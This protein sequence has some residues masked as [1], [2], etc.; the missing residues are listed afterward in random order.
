MGGRVLTTKLY[1]PPHR[2]AAIHRWQLTQRL[3]AAFH[4]NHQL[5]L[6]SAPAGY[7]KTTLVAEWTHATLNRPEPAA[8]MAWLSLED[9]DNDTTR[10]L[11]YWISSI[12]RMDETIGQ[13]A[14][15]LLGM[16][17]IPPPR[18]IL[19]ELL[20]ELATLT[21]QAILVLDDYHVISNTEL[22]EALEHFIQHRPTPVHLVITTR[23][24]P[25]FPLARLRSRGMLT[26]IR[27]H[28]LRFTAE[29]ALRFFN[30]SMHLDLDIDAV[31]ALETRTEGWAA[32]LQLAGMAIRNLPNREDFLRDFNGTH[33]YIIDYLLDEVLEHQSPAT[34]EFLSR[35][36]VLKR[37]NADLARTVT[38]NPD[39]AAILAH[40]ERFNL[41]LVPLDDQRIWYRYHQLLADVLHTGLTA[42]EEHEVRTRAAGWL[43]AHELL[44]E[45]IPHWLAIGFADQAGRLINR[46]AADLLRDGEVQTVLGWLDALPEQTVDADPDLVSYKALSL[47]LTAQVS[48]A[49]DCVARASQTFQD[50]TQGA[51]LGRLLALQAWFAM[52]GGDARSGDLAQA[53]LA[54]LD[55]SRAFFRALTLIALGDYQAWQARLS[56]SSRAFREALHLGQRMNHPF[57]ALGALANLA[58]NLLEQGQL[59]EAEALCRAALEEYVDD[60]GRPLAILGIIYS[61]LSS[62]CYEK[63]DFDEAQTFA[64]HGIALSQRLFSSVILGGDSE[65]ILA[66]IAFQRGDSDQAFDLLRSTAASARQRDAM[67]V[68]YKMAVVQTE[69]LLLENKTADAEIRLDELANWAQSSLPK[70]Q[71]ILAHLRARLWAA[72]GQIEN[73]M[74]LL[75]RLEQIDNQQG[76]GRRLIG[77]HLTR[78]LAYER[79][80]LRTA[81]LTAFQAALRLAAPEGFMSAFLPHSGW[82][83]HSLLCTAR[84]AHTGN[85]AFSAFVERVLA[86]AQLPAMS[87]APAVTQ[88]PEPLTEQELN[89]L[90][91]VQAG[92]SNQEIADELVITYGTAKWHVHNLLQKL[93][94]NSRVEAAARAHDLKI[95]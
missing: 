67:M 8:R 18:A 44:A 1:A 93:G 15:S 68:A 7:G 71:Q 90:K 61:P 6:V 12:R 17:Q 40:L 63:G 42:D 46:L 80:S 87:V 45:A 88:L 48:Q 84:R 66:R 60:S 77:V 83:T 13:N 37:F 49:Q 19:D 86:T 57:I 74:Q 3:D 20:N 11:T 56:E 52:T 16:P 79:Q 75:N 14:L 50:R 51:D 28:D 39:A 38:G 27:A 81:A 23:A 10:F 95:E 85:A 25:P 24:D 4:Q 72:C 21:Y 32:G 91:L 29:E 69:L 73:A 64:Q 53:A 22:H 58:Y 2:P 35:T 36:S 41:F 47:L 94:V 92:L 31:H 9:A 34:R 65:I 30:Q 82:S 62:I 5:I 43:E 78:A 54:Q 76:C 33:R 70:T 89:V 59:H 26:E 55:E